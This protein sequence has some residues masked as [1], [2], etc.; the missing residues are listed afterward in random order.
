MSSKKSVALAQWQQIETSWT[1]EQDF[2]LY[3]RIYIFYSIYCF[4]LHSYW[5]IHKC[6]VFFQSLRVMSKLMKECWYHNGAARLTA[7]RIKKSLANIMMEED[8]KGF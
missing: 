2:V 6:V 4:N 7:L 5:A 3:F 8:I 1:I